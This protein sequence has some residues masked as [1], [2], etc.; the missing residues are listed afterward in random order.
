[1][2]TARTAAVAVAPRIVY[3]V[4]WNS[5]KPP[6]SEAADAAAKAAKAAK[7]AALDAR[8]ELQKDW[9]APVVTYEQVKQMSEAP[10]TVRT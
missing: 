2:H 1:M 5:T 9:T 6:V 3:A 8:D 10:G 4:R 7:K